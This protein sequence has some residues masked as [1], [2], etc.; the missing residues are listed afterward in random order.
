MSTQFSTL[1]SSTL[2]L[3]DQFQGTL[4]TSSTVDSA[5]TTTEDSSK[6]AKPLPLL[7]ASSAALRAQVTKLSLLAIT[8]PFTHSAVSTV[9]R[10]VNDSVLPS[11]ITA[12]LLVTPGE[13]T[14]AYHSEVLVLSRNT[15]SEFSALVRLVNSLPEKGDQTPK[16]NSESKGADEP[17][18]QSEKDAITVA[19]GRVWDACDNL[20]AVANKGVVGFVMFRVEQWRDLIRDA[21]EEIEEW[22]PEEDGDD[23]FD[24]LMGNESK[25]GDDD[26][27]DDDVSDDEENTAK[28]QEQKKTTLRLLKPIAQI[29]PAIINNRLKNAG[30]A[31]LFATTSVA[32]LES[33]LLHLGEIPD[34]IDEVAGALYENDVSRSTGF[35]K[36]IQKNATQAVTSVSAPWKTVEASDKQP[37]EDKFTV[38]SKTW[39]KVMDEVSKSIN[40]E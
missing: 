35:L 22:D 29:Y 23:F 33:L 27:D 18:S 10:A 9:L 2:A 1:I 38:W 11:L 7:A 34:Q 25:P 6:D 26:S 21:V 24:D 28:L 15:L 13:Y 16:D 4:S 39:L 20:T 31:P 30:E 14:K 36:K 37:A 40:A 5:T 12:A 32:K 17:P 19:A 3:L 8:A